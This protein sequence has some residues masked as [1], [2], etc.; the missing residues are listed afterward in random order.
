[1]TTADETEAY[2]TRIRHTYLDAAAVAHQDGDLAFAAEMDKAL[3][4]VEARWAAEDTA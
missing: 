1:M 2:R 3:A 4:E